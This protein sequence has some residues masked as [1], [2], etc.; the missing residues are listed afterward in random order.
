MTPQVP[1]AERVE[2]SRECRH[3]CLVF[4]NVMWFEHILRAFHGR[5]SSSITLPVDVSSTWFTRICAASVTA[6]ECF[7]KCLDHC[8]IAERKL[9]RAAFR[10]C[11]RHQLLWHWTSHVVYDVVWIRECSFAL[12]VCR[13]VGTK[14]VPTA[15]NSTSLQ[16]TGEQSTFSIYSGDAAR[17]LP[18]LSNATVY[19]TENRSIRT[20]LGS[21][22]CWTCSFVSWG[23][24]TRL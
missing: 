5:I 10:K 21:S 2:D 1:P 8:F 3:T 23:R 24:F 22:A 13:G 6:L 20:A 9:R 15:L 17:T 14:L 19:S 18:V 4:L 7:G 11:L 12:V 16:H